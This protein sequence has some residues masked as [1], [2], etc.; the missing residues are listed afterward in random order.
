M[1]RNSNTLATLAAV[2]VAV[3]AGPG[4]AITVD[5]IT[6]AVSLVF[7]DANGVIVA[8]DSDLS[9]EV[10]DTGLT[11]P[12]NAR[13]A[14][15]GGAF[16]ASIGVSAFG[17]Y[18]IDATLFGLGTLSGSVSF[19]ERLTNDTSFAEDVSLSF[20]VNEGAARLVGNENTA[21][22]YR[23]E[24][25]RFPFGNFDSRGSLTG[26]QDFTANF[27]ESG[28]SLGANQ[29]FPGGLVEIPFSVQTVELGRLEAGETM[30]F[31]YDVRFSLGG[32][33][34]LE[35][36]T[37]QLTD[38]LLPLDQGQFAFT[39]APAGPAVPLPPALLMAATAFA[40]LGWIGRRRR[41]FARQQPVM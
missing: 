9:F 24:T 16:D 8:Q 15:G 20:I 32:S 28:D 14:G 6:R 41:H 4:E 23:I 30:N 13:I 7:E 26:R 38:P 29:P 10:G 37:F 31:F 1:M 27:V 18:G 33:G 11:N 5:Q 22:D 17:R 12:L 19:S 25:G 3:T 21:V 35:V 36:A 40:A 34:I 39:S 2:V